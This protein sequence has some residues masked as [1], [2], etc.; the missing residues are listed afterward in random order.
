MVIFAERI[1]G[2]VENPKYNGQ[3]MFCVHRVLSKYKLSSGDVIFYPLKIGHDYSI[4]Y[5]IIDIECFQCPFGGVCRKGRL[6]VAEGFW[7]Y[8]VEKKIR[9]VPCPF[10]YCCTGSSCESYKG[11]P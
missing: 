4:G 7:G 2:Q 6:R 5:K 10:G 11:W 1:S 9:F 8:Y 3:I